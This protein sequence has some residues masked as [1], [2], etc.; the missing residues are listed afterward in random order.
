MAK[1]LVIFTSA[2]P[3]TC[4]NLTLGAVSKSFLMFE[5]IVLTMSWE[6]YY[7]RNKVSPSESVLV[8]VCLGTFTATDTSVKLEQL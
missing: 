6:R 3:L 5:E 2:L 8:A 1:L 7:R 4:S